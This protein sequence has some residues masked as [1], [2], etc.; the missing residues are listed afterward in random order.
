MVFHAYPYA[1]V[2]VVRIGYLVAARNIIIIIVIAIAVCW[3]I[4]GIDRLLTA[5]TGQGR[6]RAAA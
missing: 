5:V 3:V 1:F 6:K 2:N 4:K